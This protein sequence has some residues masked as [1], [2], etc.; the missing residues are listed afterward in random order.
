M[1]APDNSLVEL[2]GKIDRLQREIGK[3]IVGQSQLLEET[4]IALLAG[5]HVLLEGAPGLGKTSLVR[6][7]GQ[8][9]RSQLFSD[10]VYP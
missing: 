1:E 7:L 8:R 10:P 3:V 5:G 2:Q 4:L 9:S 6:A